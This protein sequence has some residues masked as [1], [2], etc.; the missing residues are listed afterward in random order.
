MKW[1]VAAF[2][3]WTAASFAGAAEHTKDSTE[4]IKKAIADGKAIL[5]DVRE[6]SEWEDGHLNGAVLLPSSLLKGGG[7]AE[8]IAKLLPKGKVVYCHCGS[9]IRCLKAAEALQKLGYD[10]RPLK[11]G[12]AELRKEG[13]APAK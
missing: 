11:A 5:V 12:Y 9:G 13:F 7:Q 8:E 4:T 1:L 3:L 6:K 10:A 2:S